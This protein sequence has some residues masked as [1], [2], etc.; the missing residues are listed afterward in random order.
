MDGKKVEHVYDEIKQNDSEY[1][2]PDHPRPLSTTWKSQ[3][4][5]MPNGTGPKKQDDDAGPSQ[6]KDKDPELGET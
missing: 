1:D 4:H 5:R 3:Y 6:L 2:R